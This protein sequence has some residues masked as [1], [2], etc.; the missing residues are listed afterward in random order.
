MA[1]LEP[2]RST[3]RGSGSRKGKERA[4]SST[5][6]GFN[7]E[8]QGY[9]QEQEQGYGYQEPEYLTVHDSNNAQGP[10]RPISPRDSYNPHVHRDHVHK[11][12][13]ERGPY[14]S[15]RMDDPE[16]GGAGVGNQQG[17]G[18]EDLSS[19]AA[20]G[21]LIAG[22]YPPVS[23][24]EAEERRIQEHLSK[25]AARDMARRKAARASKLYTHPLP[26]N[27]ATN[28]I[29]NN[30]NGISAA[31]TSAPA[32]VATTLVSGLS[33]AST[34]LRNRTRRGNAHS[35]S[36]SSTSTTGGRG[37]GGSGSDHLGA[38]GGA[39]AGKQG[40]PGKER[41]EARRYSGWAREEGEG[42]G[43]VGMPYKPSRSPFTP[44]N[45]PIISR[46]SSANPYDEHLTT[47][48][49]AAAP[50]TGYG[51]QQRIPSSSSISSVTDTLVPLDPNRGAGAGG[52]NTP[53]PTPRTTQPGIENA[54]IP[55]TRSAHEHSYYKQRESPARATTTAVGVSY[56]EEIEDTEEMR[57]RN[58][59]G[60]LTGSPTRNGQR[61]NQSSY[62]ETRQQQQQQQ[63]QQQRPDMP[64]ASGSGWKGEH[65]RGG[66]GYNDS[67]PGTAGLR[68]SGQAVAG[69]GPVRQD[70]WWHA[71]CAWGNELDDGA[72]DGQTVRLVDE[73]VA[74][75]TVIR[76]AKPL[77]I[78]LVSLVAEDRARVHFTLDPYRV[79]GTWIHLAL[80]NVVSPIVHESSPGLTLNEVVNEMQS[81]KRTLSPV[82][83]DAYLQEDTANRKI[84]TPGERLTGVVRIK[85][86]DVDN[87]NRV[88]VEVVGEQLTTYGDQMINP[89]LRPFQQMEKTFFRQH[90]DLDVSAPN[91]VMGDFAYFEFAVQI[92]AYDQFVPA[93]S[94]VGGVRDETK[95]LPPSM[96]VQPKLSV[97]PRAYNR[98]YAEITIEVQGQLGRTLSKTLP[99]LL[100]PLD[101]T[102]QP[103]PSAPWLAPGWNKPQQ[104][105][106]APAEWAKYRPSEVWD[107]FGKEEHKV[108]GFLRGW[109]KRKDSQ[110][111][112]Q[113][114]VEV[115]VVLS[116]PPVQSWPR[117]QPIP[118]HLLATAS[119]PCPSTTPAPATIDLSDL[120]VNFQLFQ[121]IRAVAKGF[122]EDYDTVRHSSPVAQEKAN[123]GND[124][125][126]NGKF[127]SRD[128]SV[129]AP[130]K[131]ATEWKRSKEGDAWVSDKVIVGSF[132]VGMLPS[133]VN[134]GLSIKYGLK[135][136]LL[137]LSTLSR[138]TFS[139]VQP[140]ISS[141]LGG[142]LPAYDEEGD[143][144]LV[145]P[146]YWD[147]ENLVGGKSE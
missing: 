76:C 95:P 107:L 103:L 120:V 1:T 55:S 80:L 61:N 138:Q 11:E 2:E 99:F 94:S 106:L 44:T 98:Y 42:D 105:P 29:N 93:G 119:C 135:L 87:V 100:L 18:V 48:A 47:K 88:W 65:W 19:A 86:E 9:D 146:A 147:S 62:W 20:G 72:E 89:E 10:H 8:Q 77:S 16:L 70:R 57:H 54:P 64:T 132:K 78:P 23:E 145:P 140:V 108:S 43:D 30:N 32:V 53:S 85:Q 49:A 56:S 21:E 136:E 39:G 92:P 133:F 36:S 41:E 15:R 63:Q 7:H 24:E 111:E 115:R 40:R 139:L 123:E 116:V 110:Q 68:P 25:I 114:K 6:P 144:A 83:F 109:L 4:I 58:P 118:F 130:D 12:Q 73:L 104:P 27:T 102:S 66:A 13:H 74:R 50:R 126:V 121:K 97:R 137:M 59:V 46:P 131:W 82:T 117:N 81:I 142:G 31:I 101:N 38:E 34:L 79:T 35:G 60:R 84:Y 22:A 33:R 127:Q 75:P 96:V 52:R 45:I 112:Q 91:N 143:G 26:H 67:Y 71:L 113:P 69:G 125:N 124:G 129:D 141:G 37:Y 5:A 122:Y 17:L 51:Q 134:G 90:Q 128:F 28:A 14:D 3:S